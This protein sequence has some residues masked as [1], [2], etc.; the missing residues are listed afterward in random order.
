M[1][2]KTILVSLCLLILS[3]HIQAQDFNATNEGNSKRN[4]LST[5]SI[6]EFSRNSFDDTCKV[7]TNGFQQLSFK[8]SID[9]QNISLQAGWNIIST[10]IDPEYP[11][12]DSVFADISQEL[13][14]I[15]NEI[16]MI[17][18]PQFYLNNIGNLIIGEGYYLYIQSNQNIDICGQEVNPELFQMNIDEGWSLIA[19][20]RKTPADI[21]VTMNSIYS[22]IVMMKNVDGYM[23][24]PQYSINMIGNLIPGQGYQIKLLYPEQ[25]VYDANSVVIDETYISIPNSTH[26][27]EIE[28]TGNNMSLLIP[29]SAWENYPLIDEE[30]AVFS[31]ND[32]LVGSGVYTGNDLAIPVWGENQHNTESFGLYEHESFYIKMWSNELNAEYR[33]QIREWFEGVNYYEKDKISIVQKCNIQN[34]P[35]HKADQLYIIISPNPVVEKLRFYFYINE[36]S[37]VEILI[38]NTLG[39]MVDKP[40]DKIVQQ[41]LHKI[42]Y[43]PN[44]RFKNYF[45]E[46]RTEQ[47]RKRG[48][49]LIL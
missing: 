27:G 15:K 22:S 28:N 23:Y 8:R 42:E 25:F 18:W 17:Y 20:L 37:K 33:V 32:E 48:Q 12:L 19:Y 31:S 38:Y 9:C 46:F 40:M 41:G 2:I 11:M 34:Y 5:L 39:V 30:I 1:F 13:L 21:S 29:Q 16:G 43:Y 35:F 26:Y 24:W 36:T 44:V 10:Y 4:D 7:K 49:I 3:Y 45:Y 14:F 47:Y 6:S